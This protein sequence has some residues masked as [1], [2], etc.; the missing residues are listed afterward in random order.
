MQESEPP[1][2]KGEGDPIAS[3]DAKSAF[4]TSH[5]EVC[6]GTAEGHVATLDRGHLQNYPQCA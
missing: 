5:L 3:E 4:R 6:A 2:G 1:L